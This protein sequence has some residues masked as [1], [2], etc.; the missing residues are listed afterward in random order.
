MIFS[1]IS[2]NKLDVMF[3]SSLKII[4]EF[5]THLLSI[6]KIRIIKGIRVNKK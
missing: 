1:E 6:R 2:G 4:S 5:E 3:C